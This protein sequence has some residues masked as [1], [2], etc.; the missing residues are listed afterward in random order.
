VWL[1][2]RCEWP[3]VEVGVEVEVEGEVELELEESLV[4]VEDLVP[5]SPELFDDEPFEELLDELS[6]DADEPDPDEPEP[7]PDELAEEPLR[8]SVL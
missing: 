5:L 4:L 7:E 1:P 6:D 3:F 8:L 2:W